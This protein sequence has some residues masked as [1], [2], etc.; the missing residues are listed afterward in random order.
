MAARSAESGLRLALES[1]LRLALD[2]H[3]AGSCSC[4]C[5]VVGGLKEVQ[6]NTEAGV[7]GGAGGNGGER[8][9]GVGNGEASCSSCEYGVVGGLSQSGAGSGAW[10]ATADPD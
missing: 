10:G 7:G 5:G 1:G 8:R 2:E 4:E 3:R 9:G 6:D